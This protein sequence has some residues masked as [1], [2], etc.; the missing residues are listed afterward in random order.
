MVSGIR[1]ISVHVEASY[2]LLAVV[3]TKY[4]TSSADVLEVTTIWKS[5]SSFEGVA[6]RTV[7]Y[8]YAAFAIEVCLSITET[9]ESH[10]TPNQ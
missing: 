1:R 4:Q 6:L 2:R 10:E 9:Y 3:S 8:E 5:L 7:S